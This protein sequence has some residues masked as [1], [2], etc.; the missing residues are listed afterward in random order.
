MEWCFFGW[1]VKR[2]EK[3]VGVLR[4]YLEPWWMGNQV[5]FVFVSRSILPGHHQS[6]RFRLLLFWFD[7][8]SMT[9]MIFL[10]SNGLGWLVKFIFS[11][12]SSFSIRSQFLVKYY[13]V[14]VVVR[15]WSFWN[16]SIKWKWK[17]SLNHMGNI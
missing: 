9:I 16:E 14:V 11:T 2:T 15:F 1:Q 12:I 10:P 8:W 6:H 5:I 4:I 17:S 13:F 7:R 3:K